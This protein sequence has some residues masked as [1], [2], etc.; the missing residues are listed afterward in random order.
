MPNDEEVIIQDNDL[1]LLF[2]NVLISKGN[3]DKSYGEMEFHKFKLSELQTITKISLDN[4]IY[5]DISDLK[6]LINLKDLTIKSMSAKKLN[7]NFSADAK[8]N[9]YL[10]INQIKDFS[11]IQNLSNLEFLTIENDKN[12]KSLDLTNLTKLASLDLSNNNQL[13]EL[14]GIENLSNLSDLKLFRNP[15][16]TEFNLTK[17]FNSQLSDVKLDYDLYPMVKKVSLNFDET[18]FKFYQRGINLKWIENVSDLRT[19]DISHNR[20]VE[21]HNKVENILNSIIKPEYNDLE[22]LSAIYYYIVTNINYDYEA[23]NGRDNGINIYSKTGETFVSG[24]HL[25]KTY[26]KINSSYNAIIQNKC[27]CEGY[28]NMMH[29]LLNCVGI[30][31][32]TVGCSSKNDTVVVGS[33]SDHSIIRVKMG[34]DWYYFDPTCDVKSIKNGKLLY[35]FKTSKE[36]SSSHRLCISEEGIIS[37]KN[38]V[39]SIS[40]LTGAI[41][42]VV[43]NKESNLGLEPYNKRL[44]EIQQKL[45]LFRN[46]YGIVGKQIEDLMKQN[47]NN[48]VV[49][50]E[51]KLKELINERDEFSRKIDSFVKQK[52]KYDKIIK[53][54]K[55]K[56]KIDDS[57]REQAQEQSFNQSNNK[58]PKIKPKVL[59]EVELKYLIAQKRNIASYNEFIEEQKL[60][61]DAEINDDQEMT[62]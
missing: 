30:D 6:Y 41:K 56:F 13:T 14:K 53:P 47:I 59:R 55:N 46:Q 39:Y 17:L 38:R 36:I 27:V 29:Y 11:V 18:A 37:P 23:K 31:S 3:R 60:E 33:N 15:I 10:R 34:G 44:Q 57:E 8:F 28:T 12:I 7:T 32:K 5:K 2:R 61:Y 52:K 19:N 40:E 16:K 58:K 9:Y 1:G 49:D 4:G 21:M 35:Y 25:S 45:I 48:K 51:N 50:F 43:E 62:M 24:E 26:D 42:T 22:K 20:M 54:E